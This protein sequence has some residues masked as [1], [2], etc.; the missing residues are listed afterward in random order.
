M[1]K[2][3]LVNVAL[4]VNGERRNFKPGESLPELPEHDEEALIASKSIK[5]STAESDAARASAS[6]QRKGD[7]EFQEA[8]LRVQAEADSR[9]PVDA[10]DS[11]SNT[12]GE[13][14]AVVGA[15]GASNRI[16]NDISE[17]DSTHGNVRVQP[18]AAPVS[19]PA[20]KTAPAAKTSNGRK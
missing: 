10:P 17:L 1:S 4:I 3:A 9:K 16:F 6:E 15:D 14:N 18:A 13:S 5:D 12:G 20:R 19:S 2:I 8:R 7:K 11:G